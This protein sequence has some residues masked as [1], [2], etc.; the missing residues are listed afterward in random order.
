M[1]ESASVDQEFFM[2]RLECLSSA[3]GKGRRVP[4]SADTAGADCG[5]EQHLSSAY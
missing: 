3:P 1:H 5:D 4:L 2:V